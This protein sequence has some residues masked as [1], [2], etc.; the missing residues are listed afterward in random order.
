MDNIVV[1]ETARKKALDVNGSF[2]VQAPAGSGKTG[3]LTQRLLSL[4]AQ[5][6]EPEEIL[7]ITFT[8]K[9]AGE[10]RNR[11]LASL[12]RA[13]DNTPPENPH[14]L[15]TWELARKVL[16]Q[17]DH[18]QWD[19]SNSPARLRVQTIDSFCASLTRQ[20]PLLS[21]FGT[22]PAVTEDAA[23]LYAEAARNTLADIESGAEWSPHVEHLL[24][25]LDNNLHRVEERLA[26]MLGQR[27]HWLR[28]IGDRKDERLLRSTLEKVLHNIVEEYL[29]ALQESVPTD[30][31]DELI[32]LAAIAA[33]NL[34]EQGIDS[35]IHACS[36]LHKLPGHQVAHL[37][38]WQGIVQL[39]LTNGNWRKEKGVNKNLGFPT[40]DKDNKQRMQTLLSALQGQDAFRFRLAG[41]NDLPQP[42]YSEKQ[43]DILEALIEL[44]PVAV[45]HLEVVF[46]SHGQVDFTEIAQRAVQALGS[47][48]QPTDL[49]L[50]LDYRI[51]H[52][53]VDE[54]QDTSLSQYQLLERLTV[55]WTG[56]DGRT[57]FLVGDPMQSIYRFRE[58]EV[59]L[60]LR[61]RR[62]GIGLVKLTPLTLS[63][64]FRS[65]ARLVDW[66]NNTFR[67]VFP[68]EE[69]LTTGAV[70]YTESDAFHPG[71]D[72]YSAIVEP[73][74][75]EDPV[76]EASKVV[77][78]VTHQRAERPDDTIAILV[79]AR[80]HLQS[81]TRA[82]TDADISFR[83][84]EIEHLGE[85]QAVLDMMS[86]TR[87]LMHP[88]DRVAWLSVLRAP[89][90]GLGLESIENLLG[91]KVGVPV[92]QVISDPDNHAILATEERTR[93]S[94]IVEVLGEAMR[95][96]Q[97]VPLSE[98]VEDTWLA[99]GGPATLE[100][101]RDLSDCEQYLQLLRN[102]EADSVPI[103]VTSLQTGIDNLFASTDPESDDRLQVMTI[104]KA[105]GLEFDTVILPGLGRKSR[106]RSSYLLNWSERAVEEDRSELILA[107]IAA[108][109]ED[110]DS[111]NTYVQ[112]L[113]R[114]REL[115]E[116]SRLLY[117]A[118]TRAKRRLYIF[119]N[120]KLKPE[121]VQ[122]PV[123]SS[124]L[125]TLWPAVESTYTD[126]ANQLEQQEPV[127]T[128]TRGP[129]WLDVQG[130][131]R[132][133]ARWSSPVELER[134][135]VTPKGEDEEPV[136]YSWVGPSARHV[137]TLVHRMLE[138][139]VAFGLQYW[140]TVNSDIG[141]SNI[142][143]ELMSLGVGS[144]DLDRSVDT[145]IEALKR[146]LEDERGLWIVDSDH[147]D[148][149]CEF[150]LESVDANNSLSTSVI[151][152]TFI[153]NE[154]IRWIIDYK[155]SSHSGGG[156]DEFLDRE[157]ERYQAQLNRYA[158]V[159]YQLEERA[160]KLGLYFPLLNGWREWD[161]IPD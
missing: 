126:A 72:S 77:E 110:R 45:G 145:V 83:A 88:G 37:P 123:Q 130:I 80:K 41:I 11:I 71:E 7:A 146:T 142:R 147:Q 133:P 160:I 10:M 86:L 57:L 14:E 92:W 42:V 143:S 121:G 112:Y 109:G 138:S 38:V 135:L 108:S 103:T 99:L 129:T 94:R 96:R 69:D 51:H 59:A 52:I 62:H 140:A 29:R 153:D 61:A 122:S 43:W 22:Q 101:R 34:Q 102:M 104:H 131:S 53:L 54:F 148:S 56:G 125:N 60:F 91:E 156:I 4:L 46:S 152:R 120:T 159:M 40:T 127:T 158:R 21:A 128:S 136:E 81:I 150:A 132:L 105:K 36:G 6:N 100:R 141:R 93:L 5:A 119:G 107:P 89:W 28:H 19:L 149:R 44:L 16:A 31:A 70:T 26:A 25:H 78:V 157:T 73:L 33:E 137:G 76:A 23:R 24:K 117:V 124:L 49:A 63:V 95:W 134:P 114:I 35:P 17:S 74:F 12:Q 2:I 39:L 20:M 113:E 13:K 47:N 82:L 79:R 144:A 116:A 30:L 151:D 58:A 48:E 90:C 106:S 118:A 98:W 15:L 1:D 32:T 85:Q 139:I 161:F 8:H 154:G 64:N 50:A 84:V 65:Q 155:T 87:A 97:A 9:A 66:F 67:H 55:G 27:D 68:Q 75:T 18:K 115:N 3:L 111:I